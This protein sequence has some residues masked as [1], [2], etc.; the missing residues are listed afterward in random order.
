MTRWRERAMTRWRERA[1]TGCLIIRTMCL[2][3][4][5]CLLATGGSISQHFK[6]PTK[7]ICRVQ[8]G[9]H[10]HLIEYNHDISG[11]KTYSVGDK[12]LSLTLSL[13]YNVNK[14]KILV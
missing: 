5:T 13:L 6:N 8:S 14:Y 9:Y 10:Y 12:Q 3:G 4:A 7:Q 11:R 1:K 2:G